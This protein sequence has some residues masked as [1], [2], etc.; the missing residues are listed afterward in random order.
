MLIALG[1]FT[2]DFVEEIQMNFVKMRLSD[3]C[4]DFESME[5]DR[6]CRTVGAYVICTKIT[7]AVNYWW[8]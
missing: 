5:I 6:V 1:V 2:C 8:K 4:R 3:F 7:T